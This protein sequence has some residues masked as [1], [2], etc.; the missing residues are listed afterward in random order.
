MSRTFLELCSDVVSDLGV[1]GGTLPSVIGASLNNE[2]RS[3]VRWVKKAD[4]FVQ[5]LWADWRF[6]W[7]QDNAFTVL[8]GSNVGQPSLPAWAQNVRNYDRTSMY[9]GYG[10]GMSR[11]VRFM[12]WGDMVRM[13]LSRPLTAAVVPSF[14]SINPQGQVM[15]SQI[16]LTDTVFNVSY[17]VSGK[18]MAANTDTSPI[19]T[20]FDAIIVERAKIFYA[21]REAASEILSGSTAEYTDLLDKMQAY[22]LPNNIAGRTLQNNPSTM[23]SAYV[24]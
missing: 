6:L 17:H 14:W 11:G 3:I 7:Y 12:E 4:L 22:C 21:E 8:A 24:E 18:P 13:Y 20:D 23:P 15:F 19:P 10:T 16:V 9:Q 1:A 2:Q 5:L